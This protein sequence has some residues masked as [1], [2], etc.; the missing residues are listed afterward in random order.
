MWLVLNLAAV[1]RGEVEQML[2]GLAES[3]GALGSVQSFKTFTFL[4]PFLKS[5][6]RKGEQSNTLISHT[7]TV[8]DIL[9]M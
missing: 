6:Y 8:L 5:R 4:S 7:L 3:A 9:H 1:N 2:P